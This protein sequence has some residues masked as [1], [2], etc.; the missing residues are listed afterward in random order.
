[1]D[2]SSSTKN[3]K[4]AVRKTIGGSSATKEIIFGKRKSSRVA[5]Q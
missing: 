4:P 1:M 5:F 3:N 2:S